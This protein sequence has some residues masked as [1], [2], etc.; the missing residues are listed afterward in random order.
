MPKR[1]IQA[2]ET[3]RSF[4]A[5]QAELKQERDPTALIVCGGCGRRRMLGR[6]AGYGRCV[7]C[8][9]GRSSSDRATVAVASGKP[10]ENKPWFCIVVGCHERCADGV[11]YCEEH[12]ELRHG[13]PSRWVREY[14]AI[15]QQF[16]PPERVVAR[17]TN[18]EILERATPSRKEDR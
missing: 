6:F 7:D 8:R 17:P 12:D 9:A 3:A 13:L 1:W 4:Y 5:R 11:W 10:E 18:Q 2:D 15:R 14:M 16:A